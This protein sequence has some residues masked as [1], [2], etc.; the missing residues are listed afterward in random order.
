MYS[1]SGPLQEPA[2]SLGP[3]L[4]DS[5]SHLQEL[6]S[7]PNSATQRALGLHQ[8]K[9][10]RR[11]LRLLSRLLLLLLGVSDGCRAL[12]DAAAVLGGSP[13]LLADEALSFV[14][15]RLLGLLRLSLRLLLL[16]LLR[17]RSLLQASRRRLRLPLRES[18]RARPSV[19]DGVFCV[20]GACGLWGLSASAT[21][22]YCASFS[23]LIAGLVQ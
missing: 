16:R 11:F 4:L 5:R 6:G 23:A 21:C 7:H 8:L 14:R 2:V 3:S 15:A 12:L 20:D 18:R 22:C 13:R 19:S 17:L 1:R 9:S 10:S